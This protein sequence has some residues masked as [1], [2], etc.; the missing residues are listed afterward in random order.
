MMY[1][2]EQNADDRTSFP[3]TL[4]TYYIPAICFLTVLSLFNKLQFMVTRANFRAS[5]SWSSALQFGFG[6]LDSLRFLWSSLCNKSG[7]AEFKK[8]QKWQHPGCLSLAPL[9][10]HVPGY[11]K[12]L[13]KHV[14]VRLSLNGTLQCYDET[15]LFSFST[16]DVYL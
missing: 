2:E 11:M 5:V 15:E 9:C 3:Q 12:I 14:N 16:G 4:N 6:C 7:C 8:W 1:Y 13:W 10:Q